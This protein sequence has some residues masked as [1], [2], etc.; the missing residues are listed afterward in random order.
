MKRVAKSWLVI[1]PESARVKRFDAWI[2]PV[3]EK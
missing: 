3:S 2:N 1:W